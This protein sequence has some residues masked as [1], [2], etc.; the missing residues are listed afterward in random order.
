MTITQCINSEHALEVSSAEKSFGSVRVL[1]GVDLS[2]KAG[3]RIA[4]MGPSGSGKSTLL[5]CISGIEELDSGKI[6]LNG[7]LVSDLDNNGLEKLR[8]ESIGYVFQSFHLL[9]TLTAFEN[10]EL[11][12]QLIN[13]PKDERNE[14]VDDM[15]ESVGLSHRS[16]HKPDALSGG[17]RQ[18]VAIA[19][20]LIHNPSLVLAD[21]PT[22]SLDTKSGEGILTLLEKLSVDRGV[23]LLMVTHDRT[24][25]RI[26]NRVISIQD[27]SLI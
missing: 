17:E 3:E 19:R 18:R 14:K 26:C 13:M 25:A 12:A 10:I 2:I 23:T 22:G 9:P 24:S 15:L 5:N 1:K 7:N 11:P 6:H 21:E 27:G 16:D 4:L 8:R 20:A